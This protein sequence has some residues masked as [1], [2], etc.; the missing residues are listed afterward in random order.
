VE[1]CKGLTLYPRLLSLT[2][3]KGLINPR[4]QKGTRLVGKDVQPLHSIKLIY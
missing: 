2:L 3:Y 1:L 4:R